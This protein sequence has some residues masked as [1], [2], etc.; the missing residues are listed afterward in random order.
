MKT[1]VQNLRT[2]LI[3]FQ[4]LRSCT[5]LLAL[6]M[7]IPSIFRF[8]LRSIKE[9]KL[10]E[11]RVFGLFSRG[12]FAAALSLYSQASFFLSPPSR[13]Q[14]TR[15][16]FMVSGCAANNG[17]GK[18]KYHQKSSVHI[19]GERYCVLWTEIVN[20]SRQKIDL[21]I[22]IYVCLVWARTEL[23]FTLA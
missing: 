11:R 21:R 17:E 18:W 15:G 20:C 7:T 14:E 5:S 8:H 10:C 4:E 6:E 2:K 3:F 12:G 23:L 16:H 9:K 22:E 13:E 19:W 1:K